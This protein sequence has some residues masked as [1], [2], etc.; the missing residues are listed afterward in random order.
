MDDKNFF[1]QFDDDEDAGFDLPE[2]P[3]KNPFSVFDSEPDTTVVKKTATEPDA[4]PEQDGTELPDAPEG[5]SWFTETGYDE[6]QRQ[7]EENKRSQKESLDT[8]RGNE[9]LDAITDPQQ[10]AEL[11]KGLAPGAIR[12]GGMASEG[13]ASWQTSNAYGRRRAAIEELATLERIDR[14]EPVAANYGDKSH[15]LD[16]RYMNAEERE[17][18]KD[19]VRK[20]IDAEIT[21][22]RERTA[23]DVGQWFHDTARQVLPPEAGYEQSVGRQ[24]G[25]GIGSLLAGLPFAWLGTVPATTFFATAGSGE[26][27]ERAI[28]FDEKERKAGRPG[29]TD[30]KI[31]VSGLWG[32]APG[33]TDLLPVEV[34][35]GNL[36]IPQPFRGKFARAIGR[37]GGQAF[38]EGVQEG[39]Q[40]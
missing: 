30:E 40:G 16:Y 9:F 22:V 27:V 21:P 35:L 8:K 37:I 25:E 18:Y 14:G 26:A 34:L 10:Y 17:A 31:A 28:Q 20:R 19:E 32:I 4:D 36:K 15:L 29:L 2:D 39:G 6:L 12:M 11:F 13:I 24:L 7:R 3:P 33:T 23:Y 5:M 1:S 38:I